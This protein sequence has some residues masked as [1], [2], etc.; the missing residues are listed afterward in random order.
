MLLSLGTAVQSQDVPQLSNI[1]VNKS[2]NQLEIR[3]EI[4]GA[5]N[6]ESFTLFN[7][8]RLV[9]DLLQ[10]S[11]YKNPAEI[12][13][14]DFGVSRI[15]TAKNQPDVVRV[16]FD[17]DDTVPSYSIEDRQGAVYIYFRAERST[18]RQPEP[19]PV[20]TEPEREAAPQV[21]QPRETPQQ[22][23]ETA[24][25]P[26]TRG[27]ALSINLG[28]GLYM[29]QSTSFQEVYG[30]TSL[31]LGL[32]FTYHLPL[33]NVEDLGFS[34]D[35]SFISDTGTTTFTEEEVKLTLIPVM[36]S[37]FYERQFGQIIPFAGLGASYFSYKETL[38]DT[39]VKPEV[40]GNV[41]GYNFLIGTHIK[42]VPQ[43]SI[44]AQFRYHV[45]KKTDE[46]GFE[47][48]LSGSELGI[49]LSYFFN[50]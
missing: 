18:A 38:P 49:G 17:L 2:Q 25:G 37:I 21:T 44:R 27:K 28:G 32:G 31:S 50:L 34:L 3:L 39:F 43:L 7:P 16:V 9:I 12:E 35:G 45:A 42:V 6:Y 29:P 24:A 41:F 33:S 8:N 13:V 5:I 4:T 48:N 23:Q 26:V 15:R 11:E 1:H 22:V 30:K 46:D 10:V 14:N 20:R 40:T 19:K 36:L 47:I